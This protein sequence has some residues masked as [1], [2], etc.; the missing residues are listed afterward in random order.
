MSKRQA[1]TAQKTEVKAET[2][3]HVAR[4][5]LDSAGGDVRAATALMEKRVR[6]D[7]VLRDELTEPLISEACYV[8]VARELRRD[9]QRV[10]TPPVYSGAGGEAN[11]QRGRVE[12]LASSNLMM[13]PLPGGKVLGTATLED[14]QKASA[15]YTEQGADMMHKGRWLG[16]IASRL[17]PGVIV[18]KALTEAELQSLK[19]E[20]A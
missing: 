5:A 14:V 7:R 13:F 20:A 3:S 19:G 10:W 15:F 16:M 8:A 1:S 11:G 9:R 4:E 18:S 12:A 17:K 6:S 2:V